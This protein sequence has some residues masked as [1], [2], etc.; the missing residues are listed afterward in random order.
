MVNIGKE[1]AKGGQH[2]NKNP[3][4]LTEGT[5]VWGEFCANSNSKYVVVYPATVDYVEYYPDGTIKSVHLNWLD[6]DQRYTNRN[7]EQVFFRELILDTDIAHPPVAMLPVTPTASNSQPVSSAHRK[8]PNV[9]T[10][11]KRPSTPPQSD[12]SSDDCI[13]V[14]NVGDMVGES[15]VRTGQG[16]SFRSVAQAPPKM[17]AD[18]ESAALKAGKAPA[19]SNAA[20]LPEVSKPFILGL[21]EGDEARMI[22]ASIRRE[23]EYMKRDAKK[24]GE[25]SSSSSV[26]RALGS[27]F[28]M[29][30]SHGAAGGSFRPPPPPPDDSHGAAAGSFRPPPPPPDDS[31]GAAAGSFRPPPSPPDVFPAV[32]ATATRDDPALPEPVPANVT[33]A[34]GRVTKSIERY[35]CSAEFAEKPGDYKGMSYDTPPKPVKKRGGSAGKK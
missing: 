25:G 20:A 26:S 27:A 35:K 13:I 33:T 32:S 5:R 3:G 16:G 8:S 21:V 18:E 29:T 22:Q 6:G 31:H 23:E 28:N 17:S 15:S 14:E 10:N 12:S 7:P 1:V 9:K 34:Y 2:V 30:D 4:K 11:K 19:N 24:S